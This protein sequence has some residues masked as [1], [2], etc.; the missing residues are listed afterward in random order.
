MRTK[1]SPI[2]G[3]QKSGMFYI[4]D[5]AN[6]LRVITTKEAAA[7]VQKLAAKLRAAKRKKKR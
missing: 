1:K 3:I 2:V 4:L 7:R 5:F 6:G